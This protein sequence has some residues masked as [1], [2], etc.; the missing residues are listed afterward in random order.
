MA[1]ALFFIVVVFTVVFCVFMGFGGY[2]DD[3]CLFPFAWLVHLA[4]GLCYIFCTVAVPVARYSS[5]GKACAALHPVIG[6][7]VQVVYIMHAA[8]FNVYVGGML[9]ITY[10]SY[11]K[12]KLRAR[13]KKAAVSPAA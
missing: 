13:A 10:F 6:D 5:D 8:L 1:V 7:R 12:P 9:S 11:I 3:P 4:G 2:S